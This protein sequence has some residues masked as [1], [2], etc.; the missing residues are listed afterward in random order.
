M[1]RIVAVALVACCLVFAN[2][3]AALRLGGGQGGAGI[4]GVRGS[5]RATELQR[6]ADRFAVA[7]ARTLAGGIAAG[8]VLLSGPGAALAADPGQQTVYFGVGCFWHVQH[9]FV[10]TERKV[11]G[12]S[13]G[14]VTS[15][16][17]YAG[18]R[19]AGQ[20]GLV[21]YHNLQGKADYGKNGFGEVVEMKIPSAN[22]KDFAKEYFSLFASDGD[23]PD[24]GDRGPEYR[25]L[26][27]LPG[28][29]QSA[30]FADVKEAAD[31]KGIRLVEGKGNDQDTLGKGGL[32]WVMDSSKFPAYQAEV[33]HQFHDG[34]MPGEGYPE[35]YNS[36]RESA[37]KDGR[38]S[39]TG[40]PD[41]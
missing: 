10:E 27:G 33:Y 14:Q 36:L 30:L 34:F 38:I 7:A 6:A 4:G 26:L 20:D 19:K 23:R 2:V 16:A 31:A 3:C 17:G 22:V 9:E 1:A 35:S 32:V 24:K 28:G 13:T 21:C 18:G 29:V 37:L 8:A 5:W 39:P 15:R 11:L 41:I 12:R 40:C 25:S